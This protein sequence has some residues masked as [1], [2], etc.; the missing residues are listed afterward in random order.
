MRF[1]SFVLATLFLTL[2]AASA[3]AS[4]YTLATDG[5][6]YLPGSTQAY[7]RTS[8]WTPGYYYYSG[9]CQF[10]QAGY[11]SY[12]YTPYYPAKPSTAYGPDWKIEHAKIAAA[13]VKADAN[14][15]QS[16]ADYAAYQ[17]SLETLG[18]NRGPWGGYPSL[19]AGGVGYLPTNSLLAG[20]FGINTSTIYGYAPQSLSQTVD[21]FKVSLD[22]AF[23]SAFQLA[24]G[25]QQA[26]TQANSEFNN[27][28]TNAANRA[29]DLSGIAA[30]R[31]A[32]VAFSKLLDGPPVTS[33]GSVTVNFGPAGKANATPAQPTSGQNQSLAEKWNASANARCAACHF[34]SAGERKD[35]GWSVADLSNPHIMTRLLLPKEDPKHMPKNGPALTTEELALW[36][37]AI[38]ASQNEP[39]P[40]MPKL[41][42]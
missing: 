28:L 22:Q 42:K 15:R 24:Q 11:Y 13:Q 26:G 31:D 39:K 1:A 17:K 18:L 12:T 35:G 40:A 23:L 2:L 27:T 25:A 9:G 37:Q 30:R 29:A 38:A 32:I 36:A 33:N 8:A 6:Y 20:T 10:Y 14:F 7:T 4:T 34:G 3:C 41:P 16:L 21:P 5:Y 19:L